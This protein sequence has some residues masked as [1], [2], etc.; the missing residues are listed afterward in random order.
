MKRQKR[1]WNRIIREHEESGKSV[2]EFCEAKG[3]DR[4][5]F[6]KNRKLGQLRPLVEISCPS[7]VEITPIV[8][9]AGCF[10]IDISPG[11]DRRC[12]KNVL[13]VIGDVE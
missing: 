2:S 12:L 7:H 1:D 11:F 8:L 4:N 13:E 5:T 9:R 3:I 10:T 6:Y